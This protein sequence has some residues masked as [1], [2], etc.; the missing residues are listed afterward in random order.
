[1]GCRGDPTSA[2]SL[3]TG[4]PSEVRG[5]SAGGQQIAGVVEGAEGDAEDGVAGGPTGYGRVRMGGGRPAH[6]LPRRPQVAQTPGGQ[7]LLQTG[8][9]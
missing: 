5:P 2:A 6:A 7:G 3:R 8:Q 1:M 9:Q 4:G